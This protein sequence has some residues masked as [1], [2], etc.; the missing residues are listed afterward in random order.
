[1]HMHT[2]THTHAL[3][4]LYINLAGGSQHAVAAEVHDAN[5]RNVKEFWGA[6]LLRLHPFFAA[7]HRFHV[8]EAKA[9]LEALVANY[10]QQ[11]QP[12]GHACTCSGGPTWRRRQHPAKYVSLSCSF[13]FFVKYKTCTGKDCKGQVFAQPIH[14][15]C[16]GSAPLT[17]YTWFDLKVF[18]AYAKLAI[19][20]GV[21]STGV[22]LSLKVS[23]ELILSD[24]R[25][26]CKLG[27]GTVQQEVDGLHFSSEH[28]RIRRMSVCGH[29][30]TSQVR[31]THLV[32]EMLELALMQSWH[33][34]M[35]VLMH[36]Q[37]PPAL[38]LVL[39]GFK[40]CKWSCIIYKPIL[41]TCGHYCC[42]HSVRA[43]AE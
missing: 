33:P 42:Y 34:Q 23:D 3:F 41:F 43:D 36:A 38:V 30:P 20:G 31:R 39:A 14:C 18:P 10:E 37:Q 8:E 17:P 9:L 35:L 2:H 12:V 40:S 19:E 21:S 7:R 4:G 32:P 13:E 15:G 6:E 16:F 22:F 11:P 27:R 29:M 5:F 26:P 28:A 24:V 25:S 1:M